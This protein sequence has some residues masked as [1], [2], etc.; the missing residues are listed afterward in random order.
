MPRIVARLAIAL[1]GMFAA[2]LTTGAASAQETAASWHVSDVQGP[3]WTDNC[4]AD[5]GYCGGVSALNTSGLRLEYLLWWTRGRN[6][7][8]LVTTSPEGTIRPEAGVLGFPDT[9]VLFG[10]EGLGQDLR[11]GG[12][13]TYNH[14]LGD[15]CTF[16]D[17]R[18]WGLERGA[19]SFAISSD[20]EPIL[21]LPFFNVVLDAE[22][23]FLIAYPGVTTGG[24]IRALSKNDVFGFD[25]SL[26]R[27]WWADSC[28]QVDLFAGYQF[29]RIDDLLQID[30]ITTS[31]DPQA[32][33]PVGTV[34]EI[35]DRFRTK[36]EFHG[37]HVG[38]WA[39]RRRG[40][41]SLE[42]LGKV[43]LGNVR[44]SVTVA[45]STVIDDPNDGLSL[46]EGGIFAR[47]TNGGEY[48][49]NRF[50]VVPELNVNFGYEFRPCWRAM[51]GYSFI[52]WS[53]VALAGDQINRNLDL[54]TDS[55][56]EEPQ[57]VFRRSDFWAQ[58]LSFGVEHRW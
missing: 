21:G 24:S 42:V 51:I 14:L 26:R 30:S 38:F 7:P 3:A 32:A 52:Y 46:E 58:G 5:G 34:F 40:C 4:P 44:Q 23:A 12:R 18:F 10:G 20:G 45:G 6:T 55:D 1:A 54:S 25:A 13:I 47:A 22:D 19:E 17:V 56:P 49:R 9:E 11:S 41:Y 31:I 35:H 39:E 43:A 53:N 16:L 29:S 57:F 48:A 8:P 37:G 50:A 15:N 28:H 33:V 2:H 36:N 27:T